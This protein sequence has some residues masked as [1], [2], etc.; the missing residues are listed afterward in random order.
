MSK[1]KTASVMPSPSA[2]PEPAGEPIAPVI[3]PPVP[4]RVEPIEDTTIGSGET[5][6]AV[7][8]TPLDTADNTAGVESSIAAGPSEPSLGTRI[9]GGLEALTIADL[10]F[11]AVVLLAAVVRLAWLGTPLLTPDEATA[12]L[13]SWQFWHGGVS[14]PVSSPAYFSLTNLFAAVLGDSDATARLIPAIAGIGTVALVW[15]LRRLWNASGALVTALFLAVSPLALITSRTAG[16]ESIALFCLMLYFVAGLRYSAGTTERSRRAWAAAAGVGLGLGLTSAPLFYTG[17]IPLALIWWWF[18]GI[19][20]D[21][22]AMTGDETESW[23]FARLRPH[24]R[25]LGLAAVLAFTIAGS[26]LL[27]YPLGVGAAFGLLPAWLGQFGLPLAGSSA[28]ASPLL[29]ALRYEPVLFLLGLPVLFWAM[30]RRPPLAL[31]LGFWIVSILLIMFVQPGMMSNAAALVIPG[32]LLLGLAAGRL[33]ALLPSTSGR[34]ALM[35]GAGT[36]VLGL[37]VFVSLGR[38]ARLPVGQDQTAYLVLAGMMA[39]AAIVLFGLSAVADERAAVTGVFLGLAA[40]F[41]F[42]QWG[43]SWGLATIGANDPR[44]RWVSEGTDDEVRLFAENLPRMSLQAVNSEHDIDIFSAVDSAVL[45]W[46]LRDY[47][48]AQFG[49]AV[50]VDATPSAVITPA[51]TE[52]RLPADYVGDDFGLTLREV[53][54]VA[55]LNLAELLR[56]WFFRETAAQVEGDRMVFWLRADLAEN[57]PSP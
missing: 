56:W 18:A 25:P 23:P 47:R 38:Y 40:V 14:L 43:A 36:L 29:A 51:G 54:T 1:K 5:A 48:F 34:L 8:A 22:K 49:P 17:L 11:L 28:S 6:A 57:T 15:F 46:Y 52:L 4:E 3:T 53:E 31:M 10:A 19:E 12:A 32:Y 27:L 13:P 45:R 2:A 30:L 26:M 44:E 20:E 42:F 33:L 41:L 16:G 37:A 39:L 50:P 21:E 35:V 9:R 24:W 7:E 55:P